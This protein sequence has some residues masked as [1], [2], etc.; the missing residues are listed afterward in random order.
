MDEKRSL[1]ATRALEDPGS[2]EQGLGSCSRRQLCHWLDQRLA[3]RVFV[4]FQ[5]SKLWGR[6]RAWCSELC[7]KPVQCSAGLV[8][9]KPWS[10]PQGNPLQIQ[11]CQTPAPNTHPLPHPPLP[12]SLH[13]PEAVVAGASVDVFASSTSQSHYS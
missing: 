10:W 7:R 6:R 1:L 9:R 4:A 12:L 2:F 11:C 13:A 5:P 3:K 8:P